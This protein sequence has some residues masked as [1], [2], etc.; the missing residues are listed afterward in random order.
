MAGIIFLALATLSAKAGSDDGLHFVDLRAGAGIITAPAVMESIGTAVAEAIVNN[1]FKSV[2]I[3]GDVAFSLSALF[4][5]DSRFSIGVDVVYDRTTLLYEFNPPS[6]DEL[7]ETDYI[8]LMG[9]LDFKYLKKGPV[10]IYS[11]LGAGFCSRSADQSQ[12]V[13]DVSDSNFGAALQLTPIGIRVGNRLAG[14]AELGF[15]FRGLFS[16]GLALKL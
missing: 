1:D 16:A 8:S 3:D 4:L 15:G 12:P 13:T 10:K 6:L 2:T 11:S 7:F 5:P 9:R 14:W